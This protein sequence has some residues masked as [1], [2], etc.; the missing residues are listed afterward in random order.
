MTHSWTD[1]NTGQSHRELDIFNPCCQIQPLYD[2]PQPRVAPSVRPLATYS[3]GSRTRV[4]PRHRPLHFAPIQNLPAARTGNGHRFMNGGRNWFVHGIIVTQGHGVDKVDRVLRAC[5]SPGCSAILLL[6][7][8]PQITSQPEPLTAL[9]IVPFGLP[10]TFSA[11]KSTRTYLY[12]ALFDVET[13][14][15][16]VL[17]L[18]ISVRHVLRMAIFQG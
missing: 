14:H 6:H 16:Q 15:Q 10:Y 11:V 5:F 2:S 13:S 18:Y 3:W 17:R 12:R 9:Q 8:H 1:V 7:I 4:P